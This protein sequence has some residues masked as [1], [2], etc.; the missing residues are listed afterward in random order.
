MKATDVAYRLI[1]LAKANRQLVS[2]LSPLKLQK[3]LFFAAG[4]YAANRDQRLFDEDFHAWRHGP[5]VP[6]VYEEFKKFGSIDLLEEDLSGYAV[7]PN[8]EL[9]DDLKSVLEHYGRMSA[10]ELVARTHNEWVW[11][12]N[13]GGGN[14]L[15]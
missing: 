2:D 13:Y 8:A 11:R 10:Y 5:V 15:M 6:G 7:Q 12:K 4:W 3:I 9:D 1:Q 14:D